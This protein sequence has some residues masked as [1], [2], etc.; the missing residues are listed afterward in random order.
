MYGELRGVND[1]IRRGANGSQA[2]AFRANTAWDG[3]VGSERVRAA[4]FAETPNDGA[5]VSFQ[6]DNLRVDRFADASQHLGQARKAQPFP[7]IDYQGGGV[8]F[9]V[10]SG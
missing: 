9:R 3:N 4:R 1:Q 5:V 7:D 6:E 2:R 8:D 10:I